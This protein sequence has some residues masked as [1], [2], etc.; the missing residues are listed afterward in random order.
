MAKISAN[1]IDNITLAQKICKIVNK[2]FKNNFR[3]ESL[4]E[5]VED[6]KGHDRAYGL[7]TRDTYKLKYDLKKYITEYLESQ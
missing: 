2:K 1:E 5:F 6:R 7:T 4:F 3:H